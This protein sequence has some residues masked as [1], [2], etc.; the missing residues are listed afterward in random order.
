MFLLDTNKH[1]MDFRNVQGKFV[2]LKLSAEFPEVIINSLIQPDQIMGLVA[3]TGIISIHGNVRF[4]DS[5]W[6]IIDINEK[7]KWTKA[8]SLGDPN[9]YIPKCRINTVNPTE[10]FMI[11]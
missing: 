8:W 6:E 3:Q 7:E 5:L 10:L 1:G 11:R 4:L 9:L 2:A